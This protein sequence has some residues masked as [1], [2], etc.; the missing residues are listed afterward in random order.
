MSW[1]ARIFRFED[2]EPQ[3]VEEHTQPSGQ[4]RAF[5]LWR[6]IKRR[7]PTIFPIRP[8]QVED[9]G[10]AADKLMEGF[11]VIVILQPLPSAQAQRIVDILAGV[12]Y[13]LR[14][15][16]YQLDKRLF[17]FTPTQF[18]VES[19]E[20]VVKAIS[21]LFTNVSDFHEGDHELTVR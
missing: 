20:E 14:G 5:S 15:T 6:I 4:N 9:A 10:K 11:A 12:S 2:T 17:L 7:K 13:A 16:Y 21:S 3:E 19:D 1:L 8:R 18:N